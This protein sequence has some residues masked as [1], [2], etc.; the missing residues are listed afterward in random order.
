MRQHGVQIHTSSIIEKVD[1]KNLHVKDQGEIQYGILLWV[2]G[3]KSISF[4]DAL[5]VKKTTHGLGRIL[6]DRTLRV[7]SSERDG[8]IYDDVFAL[9]DAADIEGCS[10]PTTAEV[11]VQKARYLVGELNKNPSSSSSNMTSF[12]YR[13]RRLVTYI[14][15]HDGIT[16]GVEIDE[17]FSGHKAWLHWRSGSLT[18]TRTWRNWFIII[19]ALF[20]NALFGRDLA[21]I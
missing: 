16:E 7:L 20:M 11:A 6:T 4:V 5:D 1:D 8:R 17:A 10:L 2:T 15:Q 9:G 18:W 21:R 14:G 19:W 3:N 12:Q 13:R